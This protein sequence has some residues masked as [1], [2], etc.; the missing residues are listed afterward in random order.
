VSVAKET[1][2]VA[3][4]IVAENVLKMYSRMPVNSRARAVWL[5]H[6]DCEVQ[7]AQLNIKI[8]NVAG[9]ENVGGIPVAFTPP[10]ALTG[11]NAMLLGRPIIPVESCAALGTVGDIVLADLSQYIAITKGVVKA[12][13][14]MHFFF[15]Q[16]VRAFRFV[17]RMGGQP[18]LSTPITRKSGS[19]TLGHFV[20][21]ATRA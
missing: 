16:N 12:E 17:M 20:T 5:V 18:W 14:S 2:Q 21:L 10:S 7:L 19:S 9:S 4:T 15:D 3:A 6:T 13:Q 8:K 1:S 11:P